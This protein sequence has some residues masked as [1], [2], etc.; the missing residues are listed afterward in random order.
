MILTR[1]L[2]VMF[3]ITTVCP[4]VRPRLLLRVLRAATLAACVPKIKAHTTRFLVQAE[5]STARSYAVY[6]PRV[7][8]A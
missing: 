6:S 3:R 7:G 5:S 2:L 8:N 1:N 4:Q